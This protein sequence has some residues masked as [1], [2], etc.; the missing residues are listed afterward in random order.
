MHLLLN[1]QPDKDW[2]DVVSAVG[3]IVTPLLVL[4]LSGVGWRLKQQQEK[5]IRLEESLREDRIALYH[6]ILEPFIIMLMSDAQWASDPKNKNK[7]KLAAGSKIL[8]SLDYR[9]DTFGLSLMASDSVVKAYNEMFQN[10]YN[11]GESTEGSSEE[12]YR[13]VLKNLGNFLLEVRKDMGQSK[14]ELKFLDMLES[15]ITDARDQK[16]K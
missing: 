7:D 10:I 3:T 9:R 1:A 11:R 14:T 12:F 8:L 16:W 5:S 2:L 15:F 6:R 4:I 13:D